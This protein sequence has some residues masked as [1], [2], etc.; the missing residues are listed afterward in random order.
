MLIQL[1]AFKDVFQ[2]LG[3][4]VLSVFS[5]IDLSH[6]RNK[7]GCFKYFEEEIIHVVEPITPTLNHLY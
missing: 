2:V 6:V 7:P 1:T 4:G 5:W 3:Y